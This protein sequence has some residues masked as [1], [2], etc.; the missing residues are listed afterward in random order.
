MTTSMRL[1][2][3]DWEGGAEGTPW[4][5]SSIGPEGEEA[6]RYWAFQPWARGMGGGAVRRTAGLTRMGAGLRKGG[7]QSVTRQ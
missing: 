2:T 3:K 6:A 5:R 1:S 7:I 4:E